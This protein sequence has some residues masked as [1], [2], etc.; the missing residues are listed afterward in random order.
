MILY[1]FIFIHNNNA[2]KA[3]FITL[4]TK[5]TLRFLEPVV[6]H[7][8]VGTTFGSVNVFPPLERTLKQMYLVA[9]R[10]VYHWVLHRSEGGLNGFQ[11]L[12]ESDIKQ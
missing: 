2:S 11:G 5:H 7:S 9:F 10:N 12:K 3:L 6:L 4:K 1:L 8:C